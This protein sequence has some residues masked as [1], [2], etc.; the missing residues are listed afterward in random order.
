MEFSIFKQFDVEVDEA[1]GDIMFHPGL[2][3]SI[4]EGSDI[5]VSHD[6]FIS[7]A[8]SDPSLGN[9]VVSEAV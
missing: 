9:F 4:P 6:G 3:F 8:G 7:M 1:T 5:Y 2:T